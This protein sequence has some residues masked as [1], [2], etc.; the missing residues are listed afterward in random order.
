MPITEKIK[1][2]IPLASLTTFKI[3][4]AAKYFVEIAN[5][6]ELEEIF[7]WCDHTKTNY[8]I[9]GGGSNLLISEQ[10]YKGVVIKL[11][12]RGI[13]IMG[14]RIEAGAGDFLPQLVI[15][16]ST[17]GLTG[18]EWAIGI[19]G[20][21]GGAVRGNAGAFG[22]SFSYN[23]ETVE[24]YDKKTNRFSIY[25]NKDCRFDY[26]HSIFKD[27]CALVVW[28]ATVKLNKGEPAE[29]QSFQKSNLEYRLSS[30]PKLPSAGS[31]FKNFMAEEVK[32]NNSKLYDLAAEQKAIKGGKIGVGWIIGQLEISGKKI[33]GAKLSLEHNNFIVNT[34]SATAEDVIILISYIKQQVRD[35]FNLQLQEEICYVGFD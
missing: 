2:N 3:G 25:S 8:F 11:M 35:A 31:V 5:K 32:A 34:G 27:L 22:K 28:T 1:E 4:G 24:V 19:P 26:R 9:I 7:A 15:S 13:K 29:I 23:I 10:G 16:A 14:E 17:N 12:N 21:V 6:T 33:G 30:Q 18:L 20:T